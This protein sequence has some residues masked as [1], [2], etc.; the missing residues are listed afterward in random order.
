MDYKEIRVN[1]PI[2]LYEKLQNTAREYSQRDVKKRM[3]YT[4]AV[5]ILVHH[6]EEEHHS[7]PTTLESQ[8]SINEIEEGQYRYGMFSES[9]PDRHILM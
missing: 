9:H 6:L 1:I 8:E 2:N 4:E 5:R 3:S 7:W